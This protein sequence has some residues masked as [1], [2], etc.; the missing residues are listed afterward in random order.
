MS[1]II[2]LENRKLIF[3]NGNDCFSFLQGLISNDIFKIKNGDIIYSLMLNP[4]GRFL[5]EFFIFS[6]QNGFILDVDSR[7]IDDIIK[8]L[9]F[10]KLSSDV[11]LKKIDDLSIFFSE[12]SLENKNIDFHFK[13]P[14]QEDFGYRIYVKGDFNINNFNV[15][16][17][18]LDFYHNLRQKN[19]II[20][21][22]DLEFNKSLIVEYNFDKLNAIDYK[23]GCYVG[24]EVVA[25]VH[26]KGKVRKKIFLITI[27]NIKK[28]EKYSEI[29]CHN[30]NYGIILSSLLINDQLQALALIKNIDSLD[31]SIDLANLDLEINGSKIKINS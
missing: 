25:R 15:S 6:Y 28:I 22:S 2:K 3:I 31:K 26:Y 11:S 23:K 1:N 16:L 4:Q 14:R 5:Y 21:E 7:Y 12:S 17:Q 18:N 20:D 27:N 13:D 24:Q 10:Y 29:T 9:S 30:K 8:K 19:L